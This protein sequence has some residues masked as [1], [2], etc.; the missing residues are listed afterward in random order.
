VCAVRGAERLV[1]V[2]VAELR[3]VRAERGVVL[4]LPRLEA[5]VLEHHDVARARRRDQRLDARPDD[6]G[7]ERDVGAEQL[8]QARRDR[9]HR[10]LRVD[11][12]LRATEV[13]GDD[14]HRALRA[15]PVDRR[16]RGRDAEVVL[17]H[18]VSQRHVEVDAHQC[19]LPL[20]QGQVLQLGQ[21]HGS[22]ARRTRRCR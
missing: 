3:E 18:A 2:D 11:D 7:R 5:Q 13:A 16:Q 1:H 6:R 21:L 9:C 17:H 22:T 8:A 19:P 4:G 15:Q 20:L 14:H 10:V 12:A